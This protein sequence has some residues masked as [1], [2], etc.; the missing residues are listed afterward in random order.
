MI[1]WSQTIAYGN[2]TAFADDTY[3]TYRM[4]Q[5]ENILTQ[6]QDY[7]NKL[8]IHLFDSNMSERSKTKYLQL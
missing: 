2:I 1:L 7:F 8:S 6:I 3:L 5:P 4:K